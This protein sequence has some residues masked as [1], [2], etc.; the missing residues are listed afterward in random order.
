M[1]Q[2]VV[3]WLQQPLRKLEIRENLQKASKGAQKFVLTPFIGAW[4]VLGYGYI[5]F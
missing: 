2:E 3:D 1:L 4:P 5:K